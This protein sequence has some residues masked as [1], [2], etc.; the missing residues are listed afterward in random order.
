MQYP[1]NEIFYSLQGEATFAGLPSIFIRFQGCDVGCAFCDTRH[2]WKLENHKIMTVDE[3]INKTIDSDQYANFTEEEL[4]IQIYS[5]KVA[6]HVV[7]TGGEPALYNLSQIITTLEEKGYTTQIETS[8]TEELQITNK[9]WVTVSPKINMPGKK[10]LYKD[11]I[12]RANEIKMPVGRVEDIVKLKNF[13]K[14]YNII[15]KPIWLQPISCGKSAT[16]LAVDAALSNN[17][18]VSLQIHKFLNIR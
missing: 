6:R 18:R 1:I 2:T 8:G 10:K 9:T 13:I 15:H 5:Y 16:K 3:V 17:W 4:L 11:S 14:E 12:I 7:F